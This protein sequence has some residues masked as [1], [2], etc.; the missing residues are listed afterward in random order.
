M[1][2]LQ[3]TVL[4]AELGALNPDMGAIEEFK[5]KVGALAPA[6]LGAVSVQKLS[7]SAWPR[8]LR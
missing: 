8:C 5:A 6:R 7:S 1:M 3:A 2:L 4:E